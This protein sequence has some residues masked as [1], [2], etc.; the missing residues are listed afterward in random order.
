MNRN[1]KALGAW[2]RLAQVLLNTNGNRGKISPEQER[3]RSM[4]KINKIL[5]LGTT[6]FFLLTGVSFAHIIDH[7]YYFNY[8][9]EGVVQATLYLD[10]VAGGG[11]D[12]TNRYIYQ[13]ENV[14]YNP[15]NDADLNE[16]NFF[17]LPIII[18]LK[19][20]GWVPHSGDPHVGGTLSEV[21]LSSG[22]FLMVDFDFPGVNPPALLLPNP[23]PPFMLESYNLSNPFYIDTQYDLDWAG[24]GLENGGE[25]VASADEDFMVLSGVDTSGGGPST[26]PVPEPATLLLIGSGLL[27][28]GGLRRLRRSRKA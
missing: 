10:E 9:D 5:C 14:A 6:I 20:F 23:A 1:F 7:D 22:D 26:T 21:S 11:M 27:G 25:I 2:R 19:D 4:P 17:Y 18:P 12:G 28:I 13:L 16:I 3:R 8:E 24:A 15:L